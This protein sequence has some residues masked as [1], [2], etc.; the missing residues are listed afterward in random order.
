MHVEEG[1]GVERGILHEGESS[2]G[3]PRRGD[4]Q[5]PSQL[6][7]VERARDGGGHLE[8]V[9]REIGHAVGVVIRRIM[10]EHDVVADMD[11]VI[12]RIYAVDSDLIGTGGHG[13][14]DHGAFV[15]AV[16]DGVDRERRAVPVDGMDG[17][18]AVDA[19]DRIHAV[20]RCDGSEVVVG[21]AVGV[22]DLEVVE[23]AVREE[24][25]RGLLERHGRAADTEEHA[26]AQRH[27]HDDGQERDER[28]A[29]MREQL[30]EPG[31]L[32]APHPTR[33]GPPL[34]PDGG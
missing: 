8:A 10:V 32:H 4:A 29:D 12:R 6:D 20:D 30:Y 17:V 16:R 19:H 23:A 33:R 22:E 1:R 34:W 27:E 26:H 13:A 31:L 21:Q 14:L 2:D 9:R 28:G 5:R 25:L 7:E 3:S 11:V 15:D 18:R 24:L